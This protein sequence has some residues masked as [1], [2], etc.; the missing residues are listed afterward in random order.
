MQ[1]QHQY[2]SIEL[3]SNNAIKNLQNFEIIQYRLSQVYLIDVL[4]IGAVHFNYKTNKT[5]V[6]S[7]QLG[8]TLDL[9][10]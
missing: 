5:Q 10:L 6:E 8:K 3:D 4:L 1:Q 9:H 2:K 7:V